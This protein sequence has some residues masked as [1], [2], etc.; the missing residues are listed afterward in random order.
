LRGAARNAAFLF[1]GEGFSRVFGFLTTALLARRLGVDAF[2]QVGFATAVLAYGVAVTDFGLLTTA[3]RAVAHDRSTVSDSAA[4]LLPLRLLLALAAVGCICLLAAFLPKPATVRWLMAIYASGIIVQSLMMEWLFVGV[5]RMAWIAISRASTNATYF[6]LVLIF[7]HSPG[8]VLLVPVAFVGATLLGAAILLASYRAGYGPL[9]LRWRPGE[10]RGLLGE[11]W[12]IGLASALTQVHVNIGIIGLGLF[13]TY[14]ETGGFNSAYRLVFFLMTLD[15]VFYTVFLP[16][17]SRY[18]AT[19]RDRLGELTGTAIRLVLAVALPLCI[20]M[21]ILAAPIMG[22]VF[23]R[24]YTSAVPELRIMTWFLPLSMLNSLAGY[25]LVSAGMERRFLRN[26]AIGVAVAV[27][28][29]VIGILLFGARGAAMAIVVG[30]AAILCVML[31]DFL[32]FAR[33]HVGLRTLAPVLSVAL[34]API[35]FFAQKWGLAAAI[36]VGAISYGAAVTATRGLTAADI[37][38]VR[39]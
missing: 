38:L 16:V 29:N 37:G 28:A 4:S 26:T 33:P 8:A 22:L 34:M 30:E 39:R 17:V 32:S 7:V 13:R 20:G 11:A 12:P 31:P 3:T 9:R 5:E 2:G 25:T 15:R 24:A 6:L 18:V 21:F 19:Q 14:G 27:L 35:V 10:W 36:V 1:A 23:G